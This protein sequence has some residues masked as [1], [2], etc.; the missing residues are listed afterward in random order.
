MASFSPTTSQESF[1]LKSLEQK[2]L[3]PCSQ[4]VID[5]GSRISCLARQESGMQDL[6]VLLDKK[7]RCWINIGEMANVQEKTRAPIKGPCCIFIR[8]MFTNM[9]MDGHKETVNL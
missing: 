8:I 7:A 1:L 2:Q 4:D 9:V 3:S 5:F 6:L